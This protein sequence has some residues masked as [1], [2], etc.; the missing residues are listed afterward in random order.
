MDTANRLG[1]W[2]QFKDGVM[3]GSGFCKRAADAV[4]KAFGIP[5]LQG[6]HADTGTEDTGDEPM[7]EE[8]QQFAQ[9]VTSLGRLFPFVRPSPT[10]RARLKEA[11]LAE[12]RQRLAYRAVVPAPQEGGISLGAQASRLPGSWRW[13]LAATVPL[14]I[15]VLA[16]ILWRRSHRS[17]AR[18]VSPVGGQ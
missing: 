17:D 4:A 3:T 8:E 7:Q 13:S 16:T 6:S 11:L 9:M 12:H 2:R 15:G 1:W 10:F 18:L 14:L 5:F